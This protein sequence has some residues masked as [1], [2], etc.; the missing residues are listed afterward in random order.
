[1]MT[2]DL[3]FHGE[4]AAAGG[5]FQYMN[6]KLDR[7]IETVFIMTDYKWLYISSTIVKEVAKHGGD[8]RGMVPELV[9]ERMLEKYG[10]TDSRKEG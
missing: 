6:R 10:L 1:M 7:A 4:Q 8:I 3:H 2:S 5:R 9:R